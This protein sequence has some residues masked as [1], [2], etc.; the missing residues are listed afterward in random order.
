MMINNNL[1]SGTG[2]KNIKTNV[3]QKVN[4]ILE[5]KGTEDLK[6]SI[7]DSVSVDMDGD[8]ESTVGGIIGATTTIGAGIGLVKELFSPNISLLN[9]IKST[10]WGGAWG[11]VI[12][13]YLFAFLTALFGYETTW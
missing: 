7:D 10:L 6:Q 2:S 12:G 4:Q 8:D 3:L 13:G 9:V 5:K 11:F 1:Y